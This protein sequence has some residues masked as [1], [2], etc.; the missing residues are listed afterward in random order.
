M[1][2]ISED[3]RAIGVPED[4]F[5]LAFNPPQVRGVPSAKLVA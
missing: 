5:A 2:G 4:D 1:D 3:L